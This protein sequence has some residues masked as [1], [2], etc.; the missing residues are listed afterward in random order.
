[1]KTLDTNKVI[2]ENVF[3]SYVGRVIRSSKLRFLKANN[4][5]AP[6]AEE[7]RLRAFFTSISRVPQ[8]ILRL[9]IERV[10]EEMKSKTSALH[11]ALVETKTAELKG[12]I[13]AV[14]RL[15]GR[16]CWRYRL[17]LPATGFG[18][19]GNRKNK[20]LV[21]ITPNPCIRIVYAK[22]NGA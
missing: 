21:G 13:Q 15:L 11:G 9:A 20:L 4:L 6:Y 22:R 10:G 8:K 12:V 17:I 3:N 16:D 5:N 2:S 7:S 19:L 18:L 14:T 1:M